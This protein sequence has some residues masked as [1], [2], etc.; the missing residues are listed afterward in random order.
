M[1]HRRPYSIGKLGM[2][3]LELHVLLFML[4]V[5]VVLAIAVA[6]FGDE[7]AAGE[8]LDND[9]LEIEVADIPV[10]ATLAA[11]SYELG[12]NARIPEIPPAEEPEPVYEEQVYEEYYEEPVYEWGYEEPVYYAPAPLYSGGTDL[13]TD[14]VVYGDDGTR[15]TWYSQNILPGGGLDIPGRSVSEEGYVTDGDGRIAVASS[16][17]AYGTELGTPWGDA[18]VYDTGCASGTVDVYTNW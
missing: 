8:Q 17:Y 18:V 1:K 15:Y 10:A 12:T 5:I 9:A 13:K 2:Y 14:G 4:L 3:A 7:E 11:T 16:D 6:V